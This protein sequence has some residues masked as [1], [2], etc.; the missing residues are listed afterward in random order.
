MAKSK[1]ATIKDQGEEILFLQAQLALQTGQEMPASLQKNT[2]LAHKVIADARKA[3]QQQGISIVSPQQGS[4]GPP[5]SGTGSP[6]EGAPMPALKAPPPQVAAATTQ[7]SNQLAPTGGVEYSISEA[8]ANPSQVAA[9]ASAKQEFR[10][11]IRKAI[12]NKVY[13]KCKLVVGEKTALVLT[14]MVLDSLQIARFQ[15]NDPETKARKGEWCKKWKKLCC[16]TLNLVRGYAQGRLRAAF[17]DYRKTNGVY[18]TIKDLKNCAFRLLD[19]NNQQHVKLMAW[20]VDQWLSKGTANESDWSEE[21]HR[22]TTISEA[23]PPA[24]TAKDLYMPPSTEAMSLCLAEN[25]ETRWPRH[26]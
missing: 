14:E 21:K 26:V 17:E 4:Y 13:R 19:P 8:I 9:A 24:G 1:D 6:S 5:T 2:R 16:Q 23:K 15:G 22:Y 20:Y 18:V 25:N 11:L 7:F 10:T 3:L 12:R